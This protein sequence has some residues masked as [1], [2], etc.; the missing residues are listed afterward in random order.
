MMK[1][2]NNICKSKK[3]YILTYIVFTIIIT[4]VSLLGNGLLNLISLLIGICIIGH[5]SYND[6]K[7]YKLYYF[8]FGVGLFVVD[9]LAHISINTIIILSNISIQKLAYY[10]MLVLVSIRLIEF[11]YVKL[12]VIFINKRKIKK[13]KS[14]QVIGFMII[15]L[16]SI[17]YLFTLLNYL[18]IYAGLEDSILFSINIILIFMVNIYTTQIFDN[19]SRNNE[20]QNELNLYHQ[21]S[22]LQYKYYDN[23]EKKYQGSRKLA[24]DIRN[25]LNTIEELYKANDIESAKKYTDDIHQML[26]GLN[27]KYYASNKVLNIILNDKFEQAEENN[28]K[29]ECRIGDVKLDFIRDI[30]LTTIFAN[31]LD[32]AIEANLDNVNNKYIRIDIQRFNE[33]LVINTINSINSKPTIKNKKYKTTKV[34]HDGLGIENIKKSIENYD[35]TMII[36]FTE[37]YFKVNIVIPI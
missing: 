2:Q 32:N 36:D 28:I 16:F 21:Q 20:L 26:N 37:N 23:L 29:I 19:I 22:K 5:T 4:L 18:Q 24:H 11:L 6:T 30:D 33:L 12:L 34:N 8:L 35:G 3:F 7:I 9:I 27:Q 1:I 17:F 13:L 14:N 10:Q 15:P 25:H 31:L